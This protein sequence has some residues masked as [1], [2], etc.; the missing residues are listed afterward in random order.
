MQALVDGLTAA[1]HDR[2]AEFVRPLGLL[3]VL[4]GA[5][6]LVLG[7]GF[8]RLARLGLLLVAAAVL[9]LGP[10]IALRVGLSFVGDD[11]VVGREARAIAQSLARGPVRNA[12]WLA[13][14]GL[15]I[16]LPA[17]FLDRLTERVER[18]AA[19]ERLARAG[20]APPA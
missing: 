2:W 8:G 12:L 3:S 19:S 14:A 1:R 16:A 15:A 11:D 10:A 20:Q 4:L 18:R 7:A 5:V 6:V 9:V 17:A 13:A